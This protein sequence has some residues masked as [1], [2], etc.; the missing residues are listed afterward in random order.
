MMASAGCR[1]AIARASRIASLVVSSVLSIAGCQKPADSLAE[2]VTGLTENATERP[3]RRIITLAPHLAELVYTAGAGDRLV[4]AVEY[5]DFPPELRALP[6]VGDAFRLDYEAIASL[7]PDLIL[8]WQSGTPGAVL[9]R[10]NELGYRVVT[11]EPGRLDAIAEHVEIIGGLAGTASAAINAAAQYQ[12]ELDALRQR[13]RNATALSVFYQI[14]WQPLFTINEDHVIGEAIEICGGRNIFA[15]LK[16]LSPAIS[17]EAVLSQGP[18]VIIASQFDS[19]QQ[20]AE[21][22]LANWTKW[23]NI[24]AVRDGN[25]FLLEADKMV[26]PSTRILAGI[27]ELCET[28]DAVRA[29]G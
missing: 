28:L 12:R 20:T 8:G 10:L 21:S 2:S 23:K 27:R 16:E 24:P 1:T 11:L 26:R 9:D 7:E 6:R 14:S 25:L 5:S 19:R 15:D 4:G 29:R 3:A 18:D 17:V 13:Y 22:E